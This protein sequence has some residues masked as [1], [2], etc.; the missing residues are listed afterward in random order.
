MQERQLALAADLSTREV[1]NT[2]SIKYIEAMMRR[3]ESTLLESVVREML[4]EAEVVTPNAQLLAILQAYF[5]RVN[6]DCVD[7]ANR[8]A[9]AGATPE[10]ILEILL[11]PECLNPDASEESTSDSTTALA[12]TA[13]FT[14]AHPVKTALLGLGAVALAGITTAVIGKMI[15]RG[16]RKR[17]QL[18]ALE[19]LRAKIQVFEKVAGAGSERDVTETMT[20]D[21]I[22]A[23][24]N[25]NPFFLKTLNDVMEVEVSNPTD[26]KYEITNLVFRTSFYVPGKIMDKPFYREDTLN[27]SGKLGSIPAMTEK[28][29]I[30]VSLEGAMKE[31]M[32]NMKKRSDLV[33]VLEPYAIQITDASTGKPVDYLSLR[34]DNIHQKFK[35]STIRL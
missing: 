2:R 27:F 24:K 12:T 1:A 10:E 25:A 7:E 18:A 3:K 9:E 33:V 31:A 22:E 21:E 28:I 6:S 30:V 29:D 20:D 32:K 13:A 11:N 26:K 17:D 5:G 19:K 4:N 34:H 15:K 16:A 14:M 35:V 8:R 23:I